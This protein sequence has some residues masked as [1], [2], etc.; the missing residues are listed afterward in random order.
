MLSGVTS[1]EG[2]APHAV[3]T[4]RRAG[5]AWW[6][7]SGELGM[8]RQGRLPLQQCDSLSVSL[9][10]VLAVPVPEEPAVWF[11]LPAG[12]RRAGPW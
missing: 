5:G 9:V 6:G 8:G 11:A 4:R 12:L 10:D 1:A 7:V 3:G 2:R